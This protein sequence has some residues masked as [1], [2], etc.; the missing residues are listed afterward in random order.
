MPHRRGIW[1]LVLVTAGVLAAAG[2]VFLAYMIALANHD[3]LMLRAGDSDVVLSGEV[4][5]ETSQ[6]ISRLTDWSIRDGDLSVQLVN[7]KGHDCRVYVRWA[8]GV[9]WLYHSE[10]VQKN[11]L[12]VEP[13]RFLNS[14]RRPLESGQS[15]LSDDM[16]HVFWSKDGV[17][18]WHRNGEWVVVSATNGTRYEDFI[19]TIRGTDRVELILVEGAKKTNGRYD[20][21]D[22]DQ[23][24]SQRVY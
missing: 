11:L 4:T 9:G 19:V 18:Q 24:V 23:I 15:N 16:G 7:S 20:V 10:L 1:R 3:W 6:S 5:P 22:I 17:L 12:S 21:S 2:G 13:D 8:G 14:A